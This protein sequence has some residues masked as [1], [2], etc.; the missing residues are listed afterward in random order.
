MEMVIDGIHVRENTQHHTQA[1]SPVQSQHQTQPPDNNSS[2]IPIP[3][4]PGLN[5]LNDST[6]TP[7]PN[8][9][10]NWRTS[11]PKRLQHLVINNNAMVADKQTVFANRYSKSKF[12]NHCIYNTPVCALKESVLMASKDGFPGLNTGMNP[13]AVETLINDGVFLLP[14]LAR[15]HFYIE[16]FFKRFHPLII[17]LNPDT[18]YQEYSDLTKPPSLL[19]LRCV[20]FIGSRI[21]N[22]E[23]QQHPQLDLPS[24][25][26]HRAKLLY[27]MEVETKP[28]ELVQSLLTLSF[29][30]TDTITFPQKMMYFNRA[31][32]ICLQSSMHLDQSNNP[33]LTVDEKRTSKVLFWDLF[34]LDRIYCLGFNRAPKINFDECTVQ[35][36]SKDDLRGLIPNPSTSS[37]SSVSQSQDDNDRT[38]NEKL[39]EADLDS[40]LEYYLSMCKYAELVREVTRQQEQAA[41]LAV[42]GKSFDHIYVHIGN[43]IDSFNSSLTVDINIKLDSDEEEEENA[44][45]MPE[46][47]FSLLMFGILANML[48]SSAF[49]NGLIFRMLIMSKQLYDHSQQLQKQPHIKPPFMDF[50]DNSFYY[51]AIFESCVT[52]TRIAPSIIHYSD[53]MQFLP[54]FVYYGL[55]SGIALSCFLY[56]KNPVIQQGASKAMKRIDKFAKDFRDFKDQQVFFSDPFVTVCL[57]FYEN[58]LPSETHLVKFIRECM[59]SDVFETLIGF[60]L[61]SMGLDALFGKDVQLS[62]LKEI[63]PFT[64]PIYN[65]NSFGSSLSGLD[66]MVGNK[67]NYM[68]SLL[69][70]K[71]QSFM[72]LTQFFTMPLATMIPFDDAGVQ[73]KQFKACVDDDHDA[74]KDTNDDASV[75]LPRLDL[76][77][78]INNNINANI[79]NNSI[80]DSF[81]PF[82]PNST[83]Q[84]A[85]SASASSS[86]SSSSAPAN[87]YGSNTNNAISPV[88]QQQFNNSGIGN[89]FQIRNGSDVSGNGIINNNVDISRG[90]SSF[91]GNTSSTSLVT[92]N[93]ANMGFLPNGSW[94]PQ[95]GKQLPAASNPLQQQMM[96]SNQQYI[97]ESQSQSQLQQQFSQVHL[98]PAQAQLQQQQ[99]Q[100]PQLPTQY[101]QQGQTFQQQ[102]PYAQPTFSQSVQYSQPPQYQQQF[103]PTQQPQ[104]PQPQY[105]YLP[106]NTD[107]YHE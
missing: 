36:L 75:A 64:S 40:V 29:L 67:E 96:I 34:A 53:V 99:Y 86:F 59:H 51:N 45:K 69:F 73:Y 9:P 84:W 65:V 82:P 19:F 76:N 35:M 32:T 68:K 79:G 91:N 31:I 66:S 104:Q 2:Q 98:D 28:I 97:D 5:L 77:N 33:H 83:I 41:K 27:D 37:A 49:I 100:Q 60:N 16:L 43:L 107:M 61:E 72:E 8:L 89:Q 105:S 17:F 103:Q 38:E 4:T 12:A 20:L 21:A 11:V 85:A 18:F 14:S 1:Q 55:S 88:V 87:G 3:Q 42:S 90:N 15:C 71:S 93:P 48:K 54:N 39:I 80:R 74:G 7:H 62:I 106:N 63:G 57:N 95:L 81:S 10:S 23:S 6:L 101:A 30:S 56:H 52:I 94:Q 24:V 44:G 13:L 47:N 50:G 46:M 22:M 102:Q 26:L 92:N 58:I 78:T 25:M 70:G